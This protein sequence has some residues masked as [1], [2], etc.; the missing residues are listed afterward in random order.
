MKTQ[1]APASLPALLAAIRCN[2]PGLSA[3]R[4]F[5]RLLQRVV[6]RRCRASGSVV[7]L[8]GFSRRPVHAALK[9]IKNLSQVK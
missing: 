9:A 7:L 2:A 5:N 4:F 8:T 6:G 3:S 1:G